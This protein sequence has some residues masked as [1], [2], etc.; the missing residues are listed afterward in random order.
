[1]IPKIIVVL[2]PLKA[3]QAVV[4]DFNT[5]KTRKEAQGTSI[6]NLDLTKKKG[7]QMSWWT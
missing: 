3:K 1:M 5:D 2:T 4:P 6:W 7:D